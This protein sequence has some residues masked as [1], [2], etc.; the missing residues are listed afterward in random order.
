M[1]HSLALN[2][3]HFQ[4][5]VQ[6]VKVLGNRYM[7][8]DVLLRCELKVTITKGAPRQI[9]EVCKEV[10]YSVRLGGY[11]DGTW[12]QCMCCAYSDVL[13]LYFRWSDRRRFRG[14]RRDED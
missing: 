10:H 5:I 2:V 7:H 3:S 11:M 8:L 9:S 14:G 1:Y 12:I 4:L 6:L 13:S